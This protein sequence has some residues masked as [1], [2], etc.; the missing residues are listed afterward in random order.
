M[1]MLFSLL[2]LKCHRDAHFLIHLQIESVNKLKK[3]N[4]IN[5]SEL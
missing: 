5:H 4:R 3:K 2:F 1:T